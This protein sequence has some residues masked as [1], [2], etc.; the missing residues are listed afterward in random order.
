MKVSPATLRLLLP[1]VLVCSLTLFTP[2]VDAEE[3]PE[4]VSCGKETI[5]IIDGASS[6][7]GRYAFGWTIHKS[8]PDVKD[9]DWREVKTDVFSFLARYPVENAPIVES[10]H[11]GYL[12]LNAV[13]DRKSGTCH[14]LPADLVYCPCTNHHSI[15]VRW[16]ADA[17]CVVAIDSRFCTSDLQLIH[18]GK[19]SMVVK[20][21]LPQATS[22]FEKAIA[23]MRPLAPALHLWFSVAQHAKGPVVEIDG[24][25]WR[26]KTEYEEL[27]GTLRLDAAS[28]KIIGFSSKDRADTPFKD[29]KPLGAADKRLNEVYQQL[30]GRLDR[31]AVMKLRNEQR[32]WI[33]RRNNEVFDCGLAEAQKVQDY[34]RHA[35]AFREARNRRALELTLERV[36]ALEQ[37]LKALSG[38]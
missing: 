1:V 21:L 29:Y 26:P 35:D 37:Q 31:A 9:V 23:D 24:F 38:G 32:Q 8:M 4:V 3:S 2:A 16:L 18:L 19:E 34:E 12:M 10:D 30:V 7:D 22:V 13:V 36:S 33:A 15:S 17:T 27:V 14:L 25:A 20:D 6:P 5:V 11:T 28:G